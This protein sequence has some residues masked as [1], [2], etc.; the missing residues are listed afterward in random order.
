MD[1]L[2][3]WLVAA[4]I[5]AAKAAAEGAIAVL[6]TSPIFIGDVNWLMVLSGAAMG[7]V[8]SVLFSVKGIP[9]VD[10][11]T[12]L[13]KLMKADEVDGKHVVKEGE[14]DS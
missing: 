2:R 7:A 14:D 13:P 1:A 12:A 8:L 10:D 5:R 11:G 6:G 9:E 4:G 3:K